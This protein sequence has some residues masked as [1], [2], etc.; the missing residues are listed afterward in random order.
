LDLGIGE[1]FIFRTD[2][3]D[4]EVDTMMVQRMMNGRTMKQSR[5]AVTAMEMTM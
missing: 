2:G 3:G 1:Q 5:G 4:D